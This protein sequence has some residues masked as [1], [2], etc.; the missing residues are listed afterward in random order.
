MCLFHINVETH[1]NIVFEMWLPEMRL[2]C[3]NSAKSVNVSTVHDTRLP[4]C[5]M[6][7]VILTLMLSLGSSDLLTAE[8]CEEYEWEMT[9]YCLRV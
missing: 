4:E 9:E 5:T 1:F 6:V 8:M 7:V 3:S 2:H